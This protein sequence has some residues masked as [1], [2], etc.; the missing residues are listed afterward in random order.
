M[1]MKR[2]IDALFGGILLAAPVALSVPVQ[3]TSLDFAGG[4]APAF[5]ESYLLT[6]S[7]LPVAPEPETYSRLAKLGV[8]VVGPYTVE[9]TDSLYSIA[10]KFASG[11]DYLRSTNKLDSVYIN[12]G[13]RITVHNGDGVLYQV[14][15]NKGRTETLAEISDYWTKQSGRTI[16][17]EAIAQANRLPGAALLSPGGWIEPG[18]KLFIPGGRIR[19]YDYL[20]PVDMMRGKRTYSS[21]FGNRRHPILRS[22]RFHTGVDMPRPFGTSVK[23]SRDG[24][25]IFA[26]WRDGYGR[27]IILRH[28][29]GFRTWYGHLSAINVEPGQKVRGGQVIGKVGSTG[30]STGPHL[31]F[32]VRD[33]YGKALNPRKYLP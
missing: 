32:E 21:Y 1:R 10:K 20:L 5:S 13:R 9:N 2:Q 29:T 14:R 4:R 33:R 23:A 7:Q 15:E 3:S 6:A 24:R 8:L 12:V 11:A 30:L 18:S 26:D 28:D 19:F 22:R 25:V 17:A 27:L 16:T 31:H